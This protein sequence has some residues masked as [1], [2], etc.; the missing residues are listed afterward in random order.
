VD[1]RNADGHSVDLE[2]DMKTL[3]VLHEKRD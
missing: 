3:E 2:L 1:A